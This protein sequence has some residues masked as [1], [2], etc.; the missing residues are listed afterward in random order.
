MPLNAALLVDNYLTPGV[1]TEVNISDNMKKTLTALAQGDLD[2]SH[3]DFFK[4]LDRAEN[5]VMMILAM[6]AFPR[7]LKSKFFSEYKAK[8]KEMRDKDNEEASRSAEK[9]K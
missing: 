1:E 5:E 3:L 9:V 6:G 4:A 7:F 2:Q 8:S